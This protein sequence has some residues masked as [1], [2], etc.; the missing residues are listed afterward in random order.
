MPRPAAI[1]TTSAILPTRGVERVGGLNELGHQTIEIGPCS[2]VCLLEAFDQFPRGVVQI[3][4]LHLELAHRVSV[5]K[6]RVKGLEPI[7]RCV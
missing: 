4:G 2:R 3:A 1:V 5:P 7:A 6:L